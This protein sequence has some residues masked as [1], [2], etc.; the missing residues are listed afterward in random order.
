MKS[1]LSLVSAVLFVVVASASPP[2][3]PSTA[4]VTHW[5]VSGN[6]KTL[7]DNG[8]ATVI[9][10]KNGVS[11]V[12]TNK[13]VCRNPGLKCEV[14]IGGKTYPAKWL[15]VDETADLAMLQVEATLPVAKIGDSLPAKGEEVHQWGFP[16]GNTQQYKEGVADSLSPNNDRTEDGAQVYYTSIT[17]VSG[18]SGCG[19]FN[20]ADELI[21][22][23]WGGRS[24]RESCVGLADIKRFISKY[25]R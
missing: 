10:S 21:A 23:N 1:F 15:G 13:H 17:P 8:S 25:V 20:K 2:A 4:K 12:L 14:H 18:D 11:L 9:D 3:L 5:F 24:G 19:V 16:G 7:I 22:V 6:G